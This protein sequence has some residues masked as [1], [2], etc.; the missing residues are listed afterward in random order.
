MRVTVDLGFSSLVLVAVVCVVLPAIGFVLRRKWLRASARAD[1]IKRLLVLA[2]EESA[3]AESEAASSYHYDAVSSYHYDAVP[4]YRYDAVSVPTKSSSN[5]CAVCHF[6]TTTRC[7]RCK[8]VHY[9]YALRFRFLLEGSEFSL[10]VAIFL[11]NCALSS[12][13]ASF[14]LKIG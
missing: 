8:A 10:W 9:W 7:A 12:R 6:P 5:Q 3:R 11:L 13:H 1:E 14:C 4:S 2:A